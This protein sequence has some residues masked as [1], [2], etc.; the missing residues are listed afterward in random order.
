MTTESPR[1]LIIDDEAGLR[2]S[3]HFSLA[4]RGFVTDEVEEAIP[5]LRMIESSFNEGKPYNFIVADINL[6]DING[7]KLLEVIKSK[8]PALPVI[9]ISAY[10]TEVTGDAVATKR[11]DA[12]LEKPFMVDELTQ[13]MER[14]PSR[15]VES[16]EAPTPAVEPQSVSAYAMVRV[17]LDGDVMEVFRELYFM[18]HVVYCDAVHDFY[19]MVVLLNA[20]SERDLEEIIERRLRKVTGIAD[21][22]INLIVKP[23]VEPGIQEFIKDY[24]RSIDRETYRVSLAG[25]AISTYLFVEIE[26]GH[27]NEVFPKLYF[28][29]GVVSCDATSGIYDAV[30]L[31]QSQSFKDIDRVLTADLKAIDGIVRSRSVKIINMFEM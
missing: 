15:R 28:M 21:V 3:L 22:E 30:V 10:G 12:Y 25:T 11:G 24:E 14:I 26:Q 18:D 9:V 31:L 2:R 5:A 1:V 8:Y 29:N 4:Q 20:A 6:P 19:D 13:V 23:V 17:R 7:L 16:V 27:F